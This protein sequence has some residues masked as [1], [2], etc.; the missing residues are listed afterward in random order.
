[1]ALPFLGMGL[2]ASGAVI[3]DYALGRPLNLWGRSIDAGQAPL[4]RANIY[5]GNYARTNVLP[6]PDA[7]LEGFRRGLLHPLVAQRMLGYQGVP[8]SSISDGNRRDPAYN[9]YARGNE[10]RLSY[11]QLVSDTWEQVAKMRRSRP[12]PATVMRLYERARITNDQWARLVQG[13][14]WDSRLYEDVV[15]ADYTTPGLTDI[16]QLLRLGKIS[17]ADYDLW[18]RR[19]GWTDY[20]ARHLADRVTVLPTLFELI[21]ARYRGGLSDADFLKYARGLGWIDGPALSAAVL[22]NRAAPGPSDLVRFAIREVWDEETVRAWGYDEE[23]PI[24][25]QKWM[26]WQGMGW[27][28]SLTDAAGNTI[29]KVPWPLA[30]WRAHWQIIAPSQAY[31]AVHLLRPDRMQRYQELA[32]GV[33]PFTTADLH[34]VLKVSDYPPKMRQWLAAIAFNPMRLIDIRQAYFL[35]VRD[36][37][38]AVDQLLDRGLVREDANTS[39]DLW[40]RQKEEKLR[41]QFDRVRGQYV[42][43][44]YREVRAAYRLGGLD[45]ASAAQRMVDLGLPRDFA[46]QVLSLEDARFARENL[47]VFLRSVRRSYLTGALSDAEV[48][49]TL[50]AA[51][52]SQQAIARYLR[53]WQS[54]LGIERRAL[55]TSQVAS[56]VASGALSPE[57]AAVRL[58]RLGWTLPDA[59]LL[60]EQASARYTRAQASAARQQASQA[61]QRARELLQAERQAKSALLVAQRQLRTIYPLATLKRQYCLGIRKGSTLSALLLSQGYTVDAIDGLLKEWTLEC[62]NKP[63]AETP[64]VDSAQKLVKRQTSLATI[65]AW[66]QNGVVTDS[67]ARQRLTAAGYSADSIAKYIE[68]WSRTL[69]KKS[70]PAPEG[71]PA[72]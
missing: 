29:P 6:A 69:G 34:R 22:A 12:D 31:R 46:N 7:I 67:W 39:V 16:Q 21:Q 28:E 14:D 5:L 58:S 2:A 32:P 24:P 17:Q 43:E 71:T 38:W 61:K 20:D 54:Q 15:A 50:T 19:L 3:F 36:R 10:G 70:G 57:V 53:L 63:S 40:D 25:F 8:F 47:A 48:V 44:T 72:P 52:I 41:L 1:M 55:S 60:I 65:K 45:A 4:D 26:E 33:Q 51:R 49:Q 13:F 35:N 27:G 11:L 59:Q 30:Y 9:S 66:W 62:E 37:K 68:L 23:F 42:M 18:S 64:A 56:G